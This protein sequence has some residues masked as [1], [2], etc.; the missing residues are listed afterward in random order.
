M[1]KKVNSKPF[2]E[3]LS[4]DISTDQEHAEITLRLDEDPIAAG[5]TQYEQM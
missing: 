3:E 2:E 4:K 1:V 5:I